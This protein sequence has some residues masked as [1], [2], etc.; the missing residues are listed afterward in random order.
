MTKIST[1]GTYLPP[2]GSERARTAGLDEDA[3]TLAVA[4]GCAALRATDPASVHRVVVVGRNLP[5]L[6]G[7]NAAA[8]LA[9]LGV[10]AHTAVTEVVGGAPAVLD[11][12]T[13]AAPGTLVIGT[14]S[15]GAAGAA[16][17]FCG[18]GGPSLT[19]VDRITRSMPVT[20]RDAFGGSSD[21]ADPRLLRVR[22]LGESL[23]RL[24]RSAP[25][26]AVAGLLGRDATALCDG[27]PPPLPTIGASAAVL[28]LAALVDSGH[29]GL[30]AAVE[31]AAVVLATLG[32]GAVT[33]VRD[34]RP[35]RPASTNVADRKS[36]V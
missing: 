13:D 12:L 16:A 35:A 33:V 11:A 28:A 22:G 31:Q 15:V 20:T 5:L 6:E 27:T 34:E 1:I 25:I 14:D 9:G 3:V 26:V 32:S 18:D 8:V 19:L 30:V 36:V 4:A 10:S 17:A 23:E 21:Y 24:D 29:T 2:W 7:G